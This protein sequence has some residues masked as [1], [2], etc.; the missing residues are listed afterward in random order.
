MRRD[1]TWNRVAREALENA[2]RYHREARG[3]LRQRSWGHALALDRLALEEMAKAIVYARA[4]DGLV[5]FS[6]SQQARLPFVDRGSLSKHSVKWVQMSQAVAGGV[7]FLR[8]AQLYA[9]AARRGRSHGSAMKSARRRLVREAEDPRSMFNRQLTRLNWTFHIVSKYQNVALYVD[10]REGEVIGPRT[11]RADDSRFVHE[12]VRR[13]LAAF[14]PF[15]S[16][17]LP[18]GLMTELKDTT[19]LLRQTQRILSR[20]RRGTS[21]V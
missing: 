3:L 18:K 19:F 15:V 5:T 4:R 1:T 9:L 20:Q 17:G 2:R 8:Y 21:P 14:G 11:I 10:V 16:P 12:R 7:L 6:S 13:W